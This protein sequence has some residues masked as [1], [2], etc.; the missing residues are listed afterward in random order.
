MIF[1]PTLP[2]QLSKVFEDLT[3]CNQVLNAMHRFYRDERWVDVVLKVEEIGQRAEQGTGEEDF[4]W[5]VPV[6]YGEEGKDQG[7]DDEA[8][9]H[10]RS[11][12]T[13]SAFVQP[14]TQPQISHD[15]IPCKPQGGAEELG[16]DDDRENTF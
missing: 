6:R 14:E 11:Q 1:R 4:G 12:G 16:N 5:G 9:L 13:Q 10:H 15:A 7:A 2:L 3:R 8:E